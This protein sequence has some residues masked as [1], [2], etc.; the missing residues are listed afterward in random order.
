MTDVTALAFRLADRLA[1]VPGIVAV[2]LGGSRARGAA[3]P[4]S[5]LDLGLYYEGPRALNVDALSALCRDVDE[6]AARPTVPGGWGP[7]VDGGAWLTVQGQRVDFIYRDLK[8]V[9]TSVEDAL[10]GRVTLHAQVGHPHGIHGHHYAAE[11]AL[12]I[13][14]SDVDGRVDRLK[15]LVKEYPPL[16]SEALLRQYAWQAEFW[17]A[18]ALKA[19]GRGDV[20]WLQGCAFQAVMAMVQT[21]CARHGV[22]LTN[23]KGAVS[24]AAS[25]PSAPHHFEARVRT[26]LS[27]LDLEAVRTLAREVADSA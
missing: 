24:V 1:T 7:W 8:R 2:L 25:V 3:R 20:H 10:A 12:G 15:S 5:D 18:G 13:V 16:L 4:D 11:L 17:L 21:L 19:R 22:W 26:A 23:E 27:A 6:G 14:L 9:T